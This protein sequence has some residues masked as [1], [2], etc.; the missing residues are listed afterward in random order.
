MPADQVGRVVLDAWQ[1]ALVASGLPLAGLDPGSGGRARIAF[2]A[3]LPAAA[4]AEAELADLWLV[5]RRPVWALR[6]ALASRLPAAHRWVS[7]EDVWLGAPALAGQLVAADWRIEL[8]GAGLDRE[9]IAEAARGLIAARTLPR[10]R[11]KGNTE[12]RYDLRPLVADVAV[13]AGGSGG[14][15]TLL[16]R[17][18]FSPELGA[19]RPEDIVSVLAE[20]CGVAIEIGATVRTRL[21]LADELAGP[22]GR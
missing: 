19:G 2:A 21:L 20:S 11:T 5:E 7:A 10:V 18:R 8:A 17:T 6:E 1:A 15:P 9:R 22:S 13:E 14:T 12:K 4:R 16:L 3:P